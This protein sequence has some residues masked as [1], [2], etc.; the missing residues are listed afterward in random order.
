MFATFFHQNVE[1]KNCIYISNT[2]KFEFEKCTYTNF[3][4][5]HI[6]KDKEKIQIGRTNYISD[7]LSFL[8]AVC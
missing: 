3:A 6:L 8:N 1:K 4:D 7:I 2:G 5:T